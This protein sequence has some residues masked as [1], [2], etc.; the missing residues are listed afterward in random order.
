MKLC[1][2]QKLI[3]VLIRRIHYLSLQDAAVMTCVMNHRHHLTVTEDGAWHY[4]PQDAVPNLYSAVA[5]VEDTVV[6]T[7]V[8]AEAASLSSATAPLSEGSEIELS[9]LSEKFV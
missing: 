4:V 1:T 2:L 8:Q 5:T 7:P 3:F 9:D 6:N